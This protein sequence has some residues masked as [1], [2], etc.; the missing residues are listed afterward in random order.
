MANDKFI[1]IGMD[2]S[3]S[4]DIAEILGNKTCKKILDYLADIKEASEK[5]ISDALEIPI[6]TVEYNL[7]KL[8]KSG[9]AEKTKNFFWS[10]KGR[11]IDMYKLAKKHI[12]ISPK[13]TK[14]D[15]QKLKSVV[16][17]ILISA[18]VVASLVGLLMYF[19]SGKNLPIVPGK[20]IIQSD[21]AKNFNSF[22]EMREFLK[23]KNQEDSTNYFS[24]G[25]RNTLGRGEVTMEAA[26]P[27]AALAKDSS[28]QGSGGSNSVTSHSNTNIQVE[29]VDEA[30]IVKNDG[31]Y[32][33]T[34]T[35]NKV[36]IVNAYPAENMN[37]VSKIENLSG[38]RNIFV[39]SDKL[40]ILSEGYSN[41]GGY[42]K[43]GIMAA[44]S[45]VACYGMGCGGYSEPRTDILIYDIKDRSKPI[46]EKNISIEGSYQD[47]RMVGEYDYVISSKYINQDNP[48][49]PIY[50]R[51]G[52]LTDVPIKDIYYFEDYS[53]S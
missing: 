17:V 11:K 43:M 9:L 40:V 46:L 51:N 29:G 32:I 18:L 21:E 47:T 49:P 15:M 53:S 16:P 20:N 52:V 33:Y 10:R 25:V 24:D 35:G 7:N 5:D 26:A 34:L 27:T 12:V 44:E 19:E 39:N 6:N 13:S 14:V 4:K 42:R 2:D 45:S 22:E 41:G 48:R 23:N 36:V 30:D 37:I 3:R 8:I 28:S 31:K 50:M 38:A 1:L